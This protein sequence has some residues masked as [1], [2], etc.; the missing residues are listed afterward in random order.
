MLLQLRKQRR[1]RSNKGNAAGG[2][3]EG[4]DNLEAAKEKA[5]K[6]EA[7]SE[8]SEEHWSSDMSESELV[9]DN[10]YFLQ[11]GIITICQVNKK[12]KIIFH[13]RLARTD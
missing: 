13:L 9:L 7:E 2:S 12:E 5:D 1:T 3:N 11:V 4:G 6:K 8:E 10:Y